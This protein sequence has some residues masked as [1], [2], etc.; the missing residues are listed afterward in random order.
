MQPAV[1]RYTKTPFPTYRYLPTKNPHPG[2]HP[3]GH[4]FGREELEVPF[5]PPE[6]WKQN[7]AYLFGI[8][9][10]NHGYWWEAHEYWEAVWMVTRKLDPHG[11]FLQ[12]L[13]QYSAA[14]LK[15]Y[16]DNLKGFVKL[17]GEAKRRM[18]F[19]MEHLP[20]GKH[21]FMGLDLKKWPEAFTNF[22]ETVESGFIKGQDPLLYTNFPYLILDV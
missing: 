22:K 14:L 10:Y 5:Y 11:Q 3:E 4:S 21:H 16:G 15:L 6:E 17:Y 18:N 19:C 8:D 1:P 20:K 7:Q 12:S 13:I 9:L 2:I